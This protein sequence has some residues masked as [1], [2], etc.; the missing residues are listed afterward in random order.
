MPRGAGALRAQSWPPGVERCL[1][2]RAEGSGVRE[3]ARALP[4]ANSKGPRREH[5]GAEEDGRGGWIAPRS[6]ALLPCPPT[7]RGK[8]Q[9]WGP[10]EQQQVSGTRVTKG[11]ACPG[12]CRGSR[13]S[14]SM[15]F[16]FRPP[17]AG[18]WTDRP[19]GGAEGWQPW[20][21]NTAATSTGLLGGIRKIAC[22]HVC[23]CMYIHV[24]DHMCTCMPICGRVC[25]CVYVCAHLLIQICVHL[26][27]HTCRLVHRLAH[28][29]C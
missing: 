10:S 11:R 27:V 16:T 6:W 17:R 22:A 28:G 15:A 25:V 23:L 29:E 3:A 2:T 8:G 12:P 21:A 26:S 4:V 14:W 18:A 1:G 7:G 5:R 24:C 19:P 9:G 13:P 20:A